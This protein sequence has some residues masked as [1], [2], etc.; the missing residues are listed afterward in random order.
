MSQGCYENIFTTN[1]FYFYILI[2]RYKIYRYFNQVVGWKIMNINV[3]FFQV[4]STYRYTILTPTKSHKPFIRPPLKIS[5]YDKKMSEKL[6]KITIIPMF[7][8]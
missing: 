4:L 5:V 2:D 7:K 8:T 6:K 1:L 3:E